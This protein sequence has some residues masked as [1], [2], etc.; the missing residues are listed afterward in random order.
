M[1]CQLILE[2]F[3]SDLIYIKAFNNIAADGLSRLDIFDD[4]SS[5]TNTNKVEPTLES[6]SGNF[7]IK[8]K[9]AP[10]P[11]SFKIIM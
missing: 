7:T 4:L 5:Y 2:E 6:L 8:S 9:S 3:N 10:H 1:R 11:T